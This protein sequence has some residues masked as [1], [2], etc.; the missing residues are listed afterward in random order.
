MD[1][2]RVALV[3]D[4]LEFCKLVENKIKDREDMEHVGTVHD[5]ID[6][7]GLIA[8]KK[9]DVVIL[10]MIMPQLDGLGVLEKLKTY[11]LD[12]KPTIFILSAVGQ[13]SVVT[14]AIELG[15]SYFMIKP[16]DLNALMERIKNSKSIKVPDRK[17]RLIQNNLRKFEDLELDV[18]NMIHEVGIPAHIKGY[19]YIRDSIMLSIED[20][21]V[22]SSITKVLYP[23][24]AKKYKTTSSR[25]E[26]AIRHAIEVAWSRGKIDSLENLFS[27]TVN[28]EKGKPTNSEFIA[29]IA[30]KL[31]LERKVC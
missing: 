18:T 5:G 24:I 6:A 13:E 1:K 4:N 22:L 3:D 21:D 30:D 14:K 15:A 16:F 26:R 2:I 12:N 20:M 10:D 7:V 28:S 25:V 9:P 8:E 11:P 31:R 17:G 23:T 27:Y 19:Q 29:L